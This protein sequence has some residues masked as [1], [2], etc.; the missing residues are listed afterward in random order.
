MVFSLQGEDLT[1]QFLM[2]LQLLLVYQI[3]GHSQQHDMKVIAHQSMIYKLFVDG[4]K[5][6]QLGE[7]IL[8]L[9]LYR[10]TKENKKYKVTL[11]S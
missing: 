9:E 2:M 1:R 7:T 11:S 3:L 5:Q 4:D 6:K 10:N 8:I